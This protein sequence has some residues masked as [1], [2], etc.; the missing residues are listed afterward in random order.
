MGTI[1]NPLNTRGR[2]I[3]TAEY[4][5]HNQ[6]FPKSKHGFLGVKSIYRFSKIRVST[7]V[8]NVGIHQTSIYEYIIKL[9]K[10]DERLVGIYPKEENMP[11]QKRVT[12]SFDYPEGRSPL[13]RSGLYEFE[14]TVK[15]STQRKSRRIRVIVSEDFK[16]IKWQQCDC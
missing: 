2:N 5:I 8:C 10:P 6:T 15:A 14:M 3:A 13:R 12:L 11:H 4:R 16:T 1:I 9:I 7:D